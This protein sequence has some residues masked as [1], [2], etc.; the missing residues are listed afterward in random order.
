M[1]D[2]SKDLPSNIVLITFESGMR[3]ALPYTRETIKYISAY[4]DVIE[5]VEVIETDT[6]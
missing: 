6:L 2:T 4:S 3:K 1:N 5:D